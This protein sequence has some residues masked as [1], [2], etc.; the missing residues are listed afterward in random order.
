VI[1]FERAIG[2]MLIALTYVAVALLVVGVALMAA[3]GVS[4]LSGGPPLDFGR[5]VGDVVRFTPEGFLWLGLLAVIAT[6]VSRVVAAGI[7]YARAGD[8]H[9][10]VVAIAILVV[11]ALSIASALA[12]A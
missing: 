7:G 5:L 10:V 8:Q 1:D 6:P 4:P 2:R 12:F 3:Q 11:I 9:M